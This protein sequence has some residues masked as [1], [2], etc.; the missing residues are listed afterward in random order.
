MIVDEAHNI[1]DTILGI[2]TVTVTSLALARCRQALSTYLTKFKTRLKGTNASEFPYVLPPAPSTDAGGDRFNL[3]QLLRVFD[4][5]VG[6]CDRWTEQGKDEMKT[7]NEIL[8][9]TKVLDQI[10][11]RELDAY[12]S[13]SHIIR[14][15]AGY[16]EK[17]SVE[18]GKPRP[19][20]SLSLPLHSPSERMRVEQ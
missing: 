5:L 10:N 9:A 18:D 15:V 11:M 6:F 2:H 19:S 7:V 12:L 4:A 20:S 16:A 17:S 1:I 3:K 14:K 8:T 13:E